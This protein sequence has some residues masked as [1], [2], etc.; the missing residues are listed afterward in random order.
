[1]VGSGAEATKVV[2]ARLFSFWGLV[3]ISRPWEDAPRSAG[4]SVPARA[5]LPGS[6]EQARGVTAEVAVLLHLARWQMHRRGVS[7]L[8]NLRRKHSPFC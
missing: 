4:A 2:T 3:P 7:G 6:E 8:A 5:E 1:M